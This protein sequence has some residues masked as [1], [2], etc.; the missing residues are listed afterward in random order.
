MDS[1]R[2]N[3]HVIPPNEIGTLPPPNMLKLNTDGN[4]WQDNSSATVVY[5]DSQG[6]VK[7]A[8]ATVRVAT[9]DPEYAEAN[10]IL[11]KLKLVVDLR[12]TSCLIVSDAKNLV[13]CIC[14]KDSVPSRRVAYVIHECR[15]LL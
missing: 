12:A 2:R 8:A 1:A 5:I 7:L 6:R 13:H 3:A 15:N 9:P 4:T 14:S 10:A 11:L